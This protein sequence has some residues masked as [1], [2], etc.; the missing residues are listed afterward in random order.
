M[1][2]EVKHRLDGK[3]NYMRVK[4]EEVEDADTRRAQLKK[5]LEIDRDFSTMRIPEMEDKLNAFKS[6]KRIV[7]NKVH[8]NHLYWLTHDLTLYALQ[9]DQQLRA[10]F[11]DSYVE[12]ENEID[13]YGEQEYLV[14]IFARRV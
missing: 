7:N 11:L 9:T 2:D 4:E 10:V 12:M 6:Y 3:V 8:K 13:Q 14:K 1:L 5:V